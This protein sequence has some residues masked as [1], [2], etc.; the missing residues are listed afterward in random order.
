MKCNVGKTD[1]IVRA[2]LGTLALLAG[3][4]FQSWWGLIGLAPIYTISIAWCPKFLFCAMHSQKW[5][6]QCCRGCC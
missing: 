4:Y 5:W 2:A 6:H 3:L 1:F